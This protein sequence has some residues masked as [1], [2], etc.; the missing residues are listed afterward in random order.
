MAFRIFARPDTAQTMIEATFGG[1]R[2]LVAEWQAKEDSQ[3]FPRSKSKSSIS[4]YLRDGFPTGQDYLA[5]CGLLDVD[6]LALLDY[7]KT[8][9]FSKFTLIRSAIYIGFNKKTA[10][11]E[12]VDLYGPKTAWPS[13]GIAQMYF[14]RKWTATEFD[15]LSVAH[16]DAYARLS[17]D[18]VGLAPTHPSAV[19]IAYKKETSRDGL[20]RYFGV[21][22][23]RNE[24]AHLYSEDGD[25]QTTQ[26]CLGGRLTFRTYF[27]GRRVLFRVAS[28]HRH[29][30]E[31]Q[32]PCKREDYLTFKW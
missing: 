18:F 27:G 5:V 31:I 15:N 11:R 6:P 13:D 8:G 22:L 20:W 16:L 10:L 32:H 1:L 4:D 7:E 28:L 25:Y 24:E 9:F 14:G 30:L 26:R 21:V 3:P 29:V 12:L 19:H 23:S 17:F 2:Q